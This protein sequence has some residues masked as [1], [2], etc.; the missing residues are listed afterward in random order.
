[1]SVGD[2]WGDSLVAWDGMVP[3]S[4]EDEIL[5][6]RLRPIVS[7]KETVSARQIFNCQTDLQFW[8][9]RVELETQSAEVTSACK[10]V[11]ILPPR[12]PQTPR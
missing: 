9:C 12:S 2:G 10:A 6:P 3:V 4:I 8:I 11:N 7:K 5:N 1:M